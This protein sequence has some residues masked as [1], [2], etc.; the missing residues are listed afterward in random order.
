VIAIELLRTQRP[1][2]AQQIGAER[3]ALV[4]KLADRTLTVD[5]VATADR[6]RWLAL[7]LPLLAL[8]LFAAALLL[9]PARRRAALDAGIAIAATGLVGLTAFVVV[10]AVVLASSP[11]GDRDIAAAVFDAFL[12]GFPWWCLAVVPAGVIL[13]ASAVS[14]VRELD[15]ADVPAAAWARIRREPQSAWGKAAGALA[16]I[17][18]GVLV[19]RDPGG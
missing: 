1:E 13:A 17:L 2:I 12:G 15:P 9:A 8:V 4:L 18:A 6:V 3:G 10:R 16:L 19:I 14:V 11:G 7:V 5:L